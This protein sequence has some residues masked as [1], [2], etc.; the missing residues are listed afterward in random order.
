MDRSHA[1]R[2]NG[3]L[4]WCR[5]CGCYSQHRV[6]RL[7]G[8]CRPARVQEHSGFKR[9]LDSLRAGRHPVTRRPLPAL[10][11]SWSGRM[12]DEEEELTPLGSAQLVA[13]TTPVGRPFLARQRRPGEL[14][15][16]V[17]IERFVALFPEWFEQKQK[18]RDDDPYDE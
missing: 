6:L 5:R 11:A 13:R 16:D 9:R 15:L 18:K 14:A 10:A 7:A 4:V 2:M 17:W 12:G 1:F 8:P 3:D